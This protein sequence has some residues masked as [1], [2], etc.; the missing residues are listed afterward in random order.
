LRGQPER[1]ALAHHDVL[2]LPAHIFRIGHRLKSHLEAF[3][4]FRVAPRCAVAYPP[5]NLAKIAD[6]RLQL[7]Q[8]RLHYRSRFSIRHQMERERL[9]AFS[10]GNLAHGIANL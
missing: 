1:P 4:N 9:I 3:G 6:L 10:L 7:S 5:Q 8:P 2:N